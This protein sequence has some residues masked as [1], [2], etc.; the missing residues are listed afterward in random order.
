MQLE[1]VRRLTARWPRSAL[2]M[3]MFQRPF[4]GVLDD[5]AARRIDDATL[6]SRT[7]WADRWGYDYGYY[8]PTIDSAVSGHAALLALGAAKEITK[9]VA[10]HG[11]DSLDAAERSQIPSLKLDDAAHRQWFDDVM[12]DMANSGEPNNPHK[13]GADDAAAMPSVDRMYTVQVLWDETMADAAASWLSGNGAGHIV[14]LAG[15][16]HCHDSAIVRR[17]QR[18][19]VSSV[20]SV[21][22]VIDDGNGS[23]SDAL[24]KP[25]T[26]FLVVLE[27]SR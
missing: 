27:P 5:Y 14:I 21:R 26:D 22:T 16:G 10:R 25:A 15:T 4:Q 7:G 23:V 18:R 3:E 8:G 2:G 11:L 13:P 19:G 12:A 20:I 9:R 6:R 1:T 17:M 24:V